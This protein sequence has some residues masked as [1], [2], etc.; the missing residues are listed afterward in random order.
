MIDYY[1]SQQ[2]LPMVSVSASTWK[3]LFAHQLRQG[4]FTTGAVDNI[5]HNPS[6]ATAKDSFHGTGISIMQHPSHTNGGLDR[7]VVVIGQDISSAKSVT[8]LPSVYTS[9]PPAAMK[10]KNFTAPAVQGPAKPPDFLAAEAAVREEYGWLRKVK[11][12]L[13]KQSIDEWVS[14]SAYHANVQQAVIPPAAINALL[15]LFVDSVDSAHSVAMIRHSMTIV[16][17][18]I[19]HLTPGQVPVLAADQP[20]F[21]LDKEIQWTWTATHGE[22]QFVIMFGGLHI[23]MGVLKLLG[24]WLEDSGW[25]NAL[26]QADIASSGTA[27]SFIRATHVTRPAMHTNSQLQPSTHYSSRHTVTTAH[28]M[29]AI[30]LGQMMK[31]LRSGAHSEQ[32]PVCTLTTG[33]RPCHWRFSCWCISD[34]SVKGTSSSMCNL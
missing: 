24:D 28:L 33:S 5:D 32:R 3:K 26:V 7:G 12:A 20:L 17:A 9:V 15:P 29:M 30:P 21:A 27:N 16:K 11:T 13:E 1:N 25:T 8:P 10:T 18:A 14:W 6:S 34:H 4:L 2:T 22:D 23:E 19:Q 31:S